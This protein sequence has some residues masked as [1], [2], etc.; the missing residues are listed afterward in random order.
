[1]HF[2]DEKPFRYVGNVPRRGYRLLQR[3]ELLATS[4]ELH[5]E[6]SNNTPDDTRLWK[7]VGGVVAIGFIAVMAFTWLMPNEPAVQSIA[8]L[9][10]DN[11]TGDPENQYIVEGTKNTLAQRLSELPDFSIKNVRKTYEDAETL[12]V[13]STL[14]AS[15]QQ[16][17]DLLK[18]TWLL[19]R[20]R[21]GVT[22]GSGE[23]T[24]NFSEVFGL[25][26]RLAQVIRAELAG[27]ETPQLLTKPEPASAAYNR[28][29]RGM[30]LFEHRSESDNLEA[31][32]ELFQ[33]AIALDENYGPA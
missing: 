2:N 14:S 15:L 18:V 3:V 28:L 30:Y 26:E 6:P 5:V 4:E 25:Q 32:M 19:V 24:G 21:D 23:V 29:M 17:E 33:E 9:P 13:E 1:V 10:M 12:N 16:E 22:V 7:L 11:L 8:I 20:T 27:S 31:A